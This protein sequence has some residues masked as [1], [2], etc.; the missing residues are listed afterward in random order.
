MSS[1]WGPV[2]VLLPRG[3]FANPIQLLDLRQVLNDNIGETSVRYFMGP[4]DSGA[5]VQMSFEA[6]AQS[7]KTVIVMMPGDKGMD[8][9]TDPNS[10]IVGVKVKILFT[11]ERVWPPW[12]E[13]QNDPGIYVFYW[14]AF[15]ADLCSLQGAFHEFEGSKRFAA[16]DKAQEQLNAKPDTIAA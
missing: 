9:L 12:T 2:A 1:I 16:R 6:Y 14:H 11:L 15:N 5:S 3:G 8:Y 13:R 4:P 10:R 7:C